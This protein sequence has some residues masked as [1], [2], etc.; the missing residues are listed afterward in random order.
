M[1]TSLFLASVLA[2]SITL[3]GC[4]RGEV[5]TRTDL[6]STPGVIETV[7][8][9]PLRAASLFEDLT[10]LALDLAAV[11]YVPP[12]PE[13]PRALVELSYDEYRGIEFR[14][15]AAIWGVRSSFEVQLFHPGFVYTEPVLIYLVEEG[16]VR[17]LPFDDTYFEYRAPASRAAE[18]AARLATSSDAAPGYA[19]FRIHYPMN[20]EA[21]KD[22]VVVFLGASYFRLLG[23]DQVHGLS[24]RGLAVDIA[25]ESGEEFPA[26]R[27]FW[28]E[29][30]E[31]GA[32][33]LEFYALLEGPSVVGAY[34]FDL[35]PGESTS[36]FVDARVF[37]RRD[38]AKLGVAPLSSMFL[39]GANRDPRF[40]DY[41][42]QV[43]DSDGLLMHTSRGE[44]IW[45]PLSNRAGLYVT[46]L[47]DINPRGFGLVQRERD[48][49][50]YLDLETQYHRRPSEWV[51]I[52]GDWGAGGVEL[53]ELPTPSE[54]N[55]NIAAYWAP[56]EPF[57][58]GA[59]RTYQYELRT[60]G[61]RLEEQTL[62]AVSRSRIGSD[63]L[64]GEDLDEDGGRRRF[65]VDFE[66]GALVGLDPSAEVV[67]T[68][69]T[70]TGVT[71]TPVV[72]MLPEGRGR[73]A[74]FTLQTEGDQPA[75]LRLYLESPDGRLSETWSYLWVP[76]DDG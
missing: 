3:V 57:L 20:G 43:H 52:F 8:S 30:P 26:F 66:G 12:S 49:E 67:A 18:P 55:D 42:P 15:D 48:F 5:S 59:Q 40:D 7:R 63:A 44:W 60:F 69:A 38:I 1:R 33:D 25:E 16:Q 75:D 24:S 47:R 23:K 71:S 65:V 36:L 21:S 13:I 51:H 10:T 19:G 32:T 41:R 35:T 72:Q 53:L 22:E 17:E 56:D 34:R 27:A 68:L 29:Q 58:R 64:P 76:E 46:S 62:A 74:T 31:P 39:Y 4:E 54:F 11:P 50:S 9:R 6:S 45:R 14:P 2:A 28:L 37:A 73:R 61:R 70:S